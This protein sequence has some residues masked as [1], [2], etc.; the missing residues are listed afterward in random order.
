MKLASALLLLVLLQAPLTPT[1]TLFARLYSGVF[2][3]LSPSHRDLSVRQEPA[4]DSR[5]FSTLGPLFAPCSETL[6]D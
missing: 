1:L 5:T 6:A 4:L 3:G 2:L